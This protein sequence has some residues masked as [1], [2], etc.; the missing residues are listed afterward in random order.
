L[1][2]MLRSSGHPQ[3]RQISQQYLVPKKG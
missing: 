3:F 1:F 2:E